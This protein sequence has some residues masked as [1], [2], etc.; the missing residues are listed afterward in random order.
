MEGADDGA[1]AMALAVLHHA[2]AAV[3][4]D[5]VEAAHQAVLAAHDEGAFADHVEGE[6]VARVGDVADMADDL[7]AAPEKLLL[8]DLQELGIEIGPPGQTLALALAENGA[9]LAQKRAARLQGGHGF[10]FR[11]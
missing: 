8:L 2:R 11:Y 6:V 9:G 5:I 1:A 4:A 7:P 10:G 3:P